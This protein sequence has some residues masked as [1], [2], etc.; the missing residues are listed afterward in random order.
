LSLEAG[1]AA[2]YYWRGQQIDILVEPDQPVWIVG[3]PTGHTPVSIRVLP[4]AMVIAIQ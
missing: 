1:E 2:L 3:G 4:K